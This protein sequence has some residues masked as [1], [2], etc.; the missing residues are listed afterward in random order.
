MPGGGFPGL[1][2]SRKLRGGF[3]R[4][5]P[6]QNAQVS[7]YF[8]IIYGADFCDTLALPDETKSAAKPLPEYELS[9]LGEDRKFKLWPVCND[10]WGGWC[11]KN[12]DPT[13]LRDRW[14]AFCHCR[15]SG[16]QLSRSAA[17]AWWKMVLA[18]E[19]T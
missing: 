13:R 19:K 1:V 4:T 12:W 10:C 8:C 16:W 7:Q 18:L 6:I 2:A 17:L 15:D 14:R 9:L 11:Q 3:G 5:S